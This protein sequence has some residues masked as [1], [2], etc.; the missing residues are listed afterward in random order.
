MVFI[1]CYFEVF[2]GYSPGR[3]CIRTL[4]MGGYFTADD[5][6]MVNVRLI[7]E[8]ENCRKN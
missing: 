8:W 4:I 6:Y 2:D 3:G 5:L 1:D 7:E